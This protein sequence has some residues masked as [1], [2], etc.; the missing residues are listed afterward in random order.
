M[1]KGGGPV[2]TVKPAR[3]SKRRRL[4]K[5]TDED[6]KAFFASASGW[7]DLV[8]DQ[9]LPWQKSQRELIPERVLQ[10]LERERILIPSL[11]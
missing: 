6:Y 2:V 9:P 3:S 1:E 8:Q 7:R 11:P 10:S 4:S 5:K